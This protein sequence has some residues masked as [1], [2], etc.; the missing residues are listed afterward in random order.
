MEVHVLLNAQNMKRVCFELLLASVVCLT[1]ILYTV[2]FILLLCVIFFR[3]SQK[4]L[5]TW[6]QAMGSGSKK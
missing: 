1:G 5:I 4:T 6:G 3:T 2:D